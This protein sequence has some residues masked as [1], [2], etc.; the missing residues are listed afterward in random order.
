MKRFI[1]S[2]ICLLAT[3]IASH[4]QTNNV[5]SSYKD[6]VGK[7]VFAPGEPIEEAYIV[8]KDTSLIVVTEVSADITLKKLGVDSFAVNADGAASITF[9]RDSAGKVTGLVLYTL[10]GRAVPA[11][12]QDTANNATGR[13]DLPNKELYAKYAHV[14]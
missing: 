2:A 5:D 11:K 1:F 14:E 7:Y 6:Y 13:N 8:V 9:K 4:A 12:K 3:G 10:S